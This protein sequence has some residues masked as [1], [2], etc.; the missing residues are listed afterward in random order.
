M[1]HGLV[2]VTANDYYPPLRNNIHINPIYGE[3]KYASVFFFPAQNQILEQIAKRI[4]ESAFIENTYEYTICF[5]L[6]RNKN[7]S[8]IRILKT[9][10]WK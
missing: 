4:D 9:G 7:Y 3:T 2:D 8:G 5:L 1:K 6:L 10:R